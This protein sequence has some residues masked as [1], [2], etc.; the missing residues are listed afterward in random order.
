MRRRVVIVTTEP[1]WPP[2]RGARIRDH[3]LIT[4]VA[5]E[6]DLTVLFPA[7]DA[8]GSRAARALESPRL[9]VKWF[10]PP[11]RRVGDALRLVRD[12]APMAT[13]AWCHGAARRRI[14]ELCAADAVDLLQVE[15][16]FLAPLICALPTGAR[17]ASILDLHNL[18]ETQ[19]DTFRA[20][21]ASRL[22]RGLERARAVMMRGWEARW[23]A[24]FDGCL[25]TSPRDAES[26]RRADPSLAPI[27]VP[28]GVDTRGVHPLPPTPGQRLLF[29]GR[30]A[31]RPNADA[32]RWLAREI[33]PLVRQ[34]E[35]TVELVV[36]GGE[37][38]GDLRRARMPGVTLFGGLDDVTPAYRE[39][40]IAVVPLRA[41]GGTPLKLLEAMALGRPVVATPLACAGLALENDEHV[42]IAPDAPG[43]ALA[44]TT[45][46]RD[47]TRAAAMAG[48][49]RVVVERSYGWDVA[50]EGLL[51]AYERLWSDSR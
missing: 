6:H 30:L 12:R 34:Q 50:A 21:S 37:V 9:R 49:A 4:R 16:S 47:P 27:L 31:Y 20:M 19:Y 44:V 29:V 26:L 35:P 1:P 41:G 3:A 36:V 14:A 48:R 5:R 22:A 23:A 38:P 51:A 13:W 42:L 18:A 24:R 28:N 17:V 40:Q 8:A 46:L 10:V 43:F 33:L 2:D 25:V 32:V 45:L 11:R 15:H 7:G 39:A